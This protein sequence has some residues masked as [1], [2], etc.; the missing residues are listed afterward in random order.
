MLDFRFV[1]R[2]SVDICH[3]DIHQDTTKCF[4]LAHAPQKIKPTAH[5]PH[6]VMLSSRQRSICFSIPEKAASSAS[7]QNDIQ[8]PP[9]GRTPF[10]KGA[11]EDFG[12]NSLELRALRIPRGELALILAR[13]E[14][15]P[16][17]IAKQV[18]A[19]DDQ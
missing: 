4:M 18:K 11:H 1:L 8:G 12:I 17:S 5:S 19:Q 10:F 15:I 7:P 14:D 13:V 9:C 6:D 16:Q 2:K 3:I